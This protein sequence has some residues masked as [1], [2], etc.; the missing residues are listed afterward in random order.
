MLQVAWVEEAFCRL[1]SDSD[2]RKQEK[3]T[4]I[5]TKAITLMVISSGHAFYQENKSN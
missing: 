4:E 2:R 1:A 5:E 3:S